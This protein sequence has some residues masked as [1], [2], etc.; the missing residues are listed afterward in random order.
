[1]ENIGKLYIV[2]TPI[3]NP[4]DITLRAVEILKSVNAIIV[5]ENRQATTLLKKL[6]IQ[7]RE[8]LALNEH[9]ELEATSAILMRLYQGQNLALISDCGTPVFA[10]PGHHLVQQAVESGIQ[11][12]PVPGASSLMAALSVL[13]FE[14]KRFVYAGFLPREAILR[15]RELTRLRGMNM[16]VVIMDTPYRLGAL[17]D[18]VMKIFGKNQQVVLSCNLTMP[19]EAIFRGSTQDVR[20]RLGQRK[21]EFVLI[22]KV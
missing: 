15:Q 2:S 19:N 14:P 4:G 6:N 3:G 11:V 21:A 16:T 1:M 5:E 10:D 12:I 8:L 9:N 17:M 13:D 20:Q 18:D 7:G 22:I